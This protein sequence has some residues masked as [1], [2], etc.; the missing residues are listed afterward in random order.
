MWKAFSI[1]LILITLVSGWQNA[2]ECDQEKLPSLIVAA[3][4]IVC[5][6]FAK[7]TSSVHI[8]YAG[9]SKRIVLPIDCVIAVTVQE[10]RIISNNTGYAAAHHVFVVNDYSE[11]R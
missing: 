6:N 5:S 2:I 1:Y 9:A 8:S 4:Q 10:H 11:F 3:K 7:R